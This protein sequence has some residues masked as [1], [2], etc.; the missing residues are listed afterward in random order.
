MRGTGLPRGG[1]RGREKRSGGDGRG[2]RDGREEVEGEG[3]KGLLLT[4]LKVK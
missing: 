3:G 4:L 2:E 1:S